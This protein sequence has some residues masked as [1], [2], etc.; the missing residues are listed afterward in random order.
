MVRAL[1]TWQRWIGVGGTVQ[2]REGV[3]LVHQPFGMHPAQ[4]VAAHGELPGIV[5]QYHG[6]AQE[7]VRVDAAPNG[8]LLTFPK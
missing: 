7:V 8:P 6:I 5:A 4:R 2:I 3:Q 1:W